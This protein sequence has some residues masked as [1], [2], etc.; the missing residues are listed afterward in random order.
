MK[1]IGFRK[2]LLLLPFKPWITLI[3]VNWLLANITAAIFFMI[4]MPMWSILLVVILSPWAGI[5]SYAI[6]TGNKVEIHLSTGKPSM[7]NFFLGFTKKVEK[8]S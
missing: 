4:G 2:A 7:M 3:L 1:N 5:A 8:G 6:T